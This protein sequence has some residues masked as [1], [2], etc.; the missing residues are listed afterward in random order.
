VSWLTEV[1][2]TAI[3][4]L[5]ALTGSYGIAIILVTLGVRVVLLPFTF[6]QMRATRKMQEL[7]P[8]IKALQQKYKKD[9][10]R[11]NKETMELWKKH[12]VNPLSGCLPMLLQFPFLI[13]LFRVLAYTDFGQGFLWI[14]SLSS[15]DHLFILPVLA[16]VTTYAQTRVGTPAAAAAEGSQKTMSLIMPVFVGWMASRFAAGLSLYWVVS[17]LF[18]IAQQYLTARAATPAR[19]EAG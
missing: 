13:A 6:S 12:K 14:D 3:S 19:G 7:Q 1:M 15:T 16:A 4:E 8:E 5:F 17:N 10:Q 18:S 11:L 2:K 9:P